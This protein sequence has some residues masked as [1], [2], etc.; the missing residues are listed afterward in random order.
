MEPLTLNVRL[1]GAPG[2][3]VHGPGP[4]PTTRTTSL[5]GPLVP[6]GLVARTRMKNVL[7]GTPVGIRLVTL[8]TFE[9]TILVAP[10]DEPAS[11]MYAVGAPPELGALHE[12]VAV[13]P[14]ALAVRFDGAP[15]VVVPP[16]PL[17]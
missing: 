6:A 8:P 12:I 17:R 3:P 9:T 1:V 16:P 10:D 14:E 13:E 15:G 4:P 7:F 11:K 5:D 2:A